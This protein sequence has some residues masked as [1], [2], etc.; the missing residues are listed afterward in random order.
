MPVL[1]VP[2]E[3]RR[4]F[5]ANRTEF[6]RNLACWPMTAQSP[7]Y[8]RI[9]PLHDTI[10]GDR[11]NPWDFKKKQFNLDFECRDDFFRYM[12]FDLAEVQD[13]VG[14]AMCHAPFHID[15]DILIGQ[16][17]ESVRMPYIYF[18]FVGVIEVSKQEELDFQIVPDIILE[19]F[20]RGFYVDLVTFDRFQSSHTLSI[21]RD[22]G[23]HC[24]K[25]S[26]DRTAYK[27]ISEKVIA[28]NGRSKGWRV[29]K[30]TTDRQY[31]DAHLALKTAIYE[32]RAS[33]PE[34]TQWAQWHPQDPRHPMITEALGAEHKHDGTVDH[35]TF[36]KID[37][38]SGMAGAAY[39]CQNNAPDMGERPVGFDDPSK[40]DTAFMELETR[41]N[42]AVLNNA[43][44]GV[45]SLE[46]FNAI[47][48]T[49]EQN[50][51][52]P[53]DTFY[54]DHDPDMNPFLDLGI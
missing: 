49:I 15:R 18:D 25:L 8:R 48:G 47:R 34:W 6:V 53:V 23:I 40:R 21:L 10:D 30:A 26:V 37:I 19:L 31:A 7:F 50:E 44:A 4:N 29:R 2:Q 32:A 38:L 24:G 39:N 45:S 12:H 36:S 46:Q 27:L 14:F 1:A 9:A 16:E 3:L 5:L 33:V 13:R 42:Q 54:L 11:E 28:P 43:L 52:D 35:G 41:H 51:G 17:V 20:H 22:R